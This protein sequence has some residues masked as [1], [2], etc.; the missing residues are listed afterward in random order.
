MT[1]ER[2]YCAIDTTDLGAAVALAELLSGEVGGVKLGNEFFT[3]HGPQGVAKIAATGHKIFLDLKFNDIPNTV[4]G[5]VRAA[6]GLGV[7][8]MTIHAS[9]GP[10]MMRAAA[11]AARVEDGVRPLILAVTVLT[12]LDEDDLAAVGQTGPV[13]DQV[14]HLAGLAKAAGIDGVVC[15]PLEIAALKS[16][17]GDE[18]LLVVPGVRPT[19]AA[20]DDQKR[21]MTPGD[22]VAAGAD[23]LVIGRPITRAGDPVSAARRIADELS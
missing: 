6:A 17:L 16:S 4:A 22:A 10:A 5:A 21:V 8:I 14:A 20:P 23:F 18:F 19:W 13:A 9:G 12:S 11:E 3:A 1:A 7:H 2:I 15:S